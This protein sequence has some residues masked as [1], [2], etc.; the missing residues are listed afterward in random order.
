MP[1][2]ITGLAGGFLSGVGGILLSRLLSSPERRKSELRASY[3]LLLKHIAQL[4]ARC[5]LLQK[6]YEDLQADY[7]DLERR[8]IRLIRS[9]GSKRDRDTPPDRTR[10]IGGKNG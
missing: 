2:W 4:E 3:D 7:D 5:E 1:E 9:N 8:H 10:D 6:K